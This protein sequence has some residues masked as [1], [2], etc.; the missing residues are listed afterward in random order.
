[1][2]KTRIDLTGE[3]QFKE[4]PQRA[5]RMRDLEASDW[6]AAEVPSSIFTNLVKVG[7]I[8]EAELKSN[9]E[10][11]EWVSEKQWIFKKTFDLPQRIIN[12]EK[13]EIV[14]EGLDTIAHIWLNGKLIGKTNNM[15]I[16]HRFGLTGMFRAKSNH[17]LV[18]FDSP[19]QYGR[20]LMSRYGKL[21][22]DE[23]SYPSRVYLRKAQYQFGWD[24]APSLPGCGIWR[25]V[26][27][28]A[29]DQARIEDICIRTIDCNEQFADIQIAVKLDRIS[30]DDFF[31]K[32]SLADGEKRV[33]AEQS[34]HF[35]KNED[36]NST[37][38][39]ITNPK[40]W[41]PRGYGG[42]PLYGLTAQLFCVDKLI[43]QAEQKFGIRTTKLNQSKDK[44]GQSFQF[45]VNGQA[46]Y[47]KGANWVPISLFAG[48][49]TEAD[50]EKLINFAVD[51]N[52]NMLR[53]WGGGYYEDPKF[54]ELCDELGMM[55]WQDF[56]FACAYYP[57]RNWFL[58]EVRTEAEAIIKRLRN[59]CSI[60][61][62]CGN[63]END[64]LHSIGK[65]GTGKKFY[66]KAIY[67]KLLPEL[68]GELDPGADYIPTTPL[69]MDK[70][71]NNS[72]AGS[73]H[74]WQV[75]SGLS[76]SRNYQCPADEVPRFVTEFGFQ[77]LPSFETLKTF[78]QPEQMHLSNAALEKH[79]YQSD[80][81]A[82]LHY[83]ISEQFAA[84]KTLDYFV[85]MSQLTQA[86]AMKLYVEHLRAHSF[87]NSGVLYWQHNDAYPA[88]TWSAIDYLYQPKAL[89]YYARRFFNPV[90]LTVVP[91]FCL[92]HPVLHPKLE[93]AFVHVIND[94]ILPLTARVICRLMDL[95]LNVIDEIT[96]PLSVNP[97][98]C[99]N[100]FR[101][102]NGFITP[103]DPQQSFMYFCLVH[104][105][106]TIAENSFF[107]LPDKYIT[108]PKPQITTKI[109]A[110]DGH[111]WELKLTSD[112]V[113]KDVRISTDSPSQLNDNFISLLS[114]DER[115]LR[116][117]TPQKQTS[118]PQVELLSVNSLPK[119]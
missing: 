42:Q 86:R 3:W 99:S 6:L 16:T 10:K 65:L 24:W 96:Q 105:D 12:S 79:N 25:P 47:A 100:P 94:T 74:Q 111:K 113:A 29:A 102:P 17:L 22:E 46:V 90:L 107:Y 97:F 49:A 4:Y 59:Y 67:Y 34:L 71:F 110:I 63:N 28:E 20:A 1:M 58:K 38:V 31:C 61:L 87:R 73:V 103:E 81:N 106:Y 9:P 75:W 40:L 104:D 7:R 45:E 109:S 82:R 33:Q 68:V 60:V 84:A 114:R 119:D 55:V 35:K 32:L 56:A 89:H 64:W 13:I 8:D 14:F 85:Y 50:Y 80:G 98:S 52:M 76:P 43:D 54:Y 112:V 70:N 78:T 51:A 37:I 118:P 95:S 11:F 21:S 117:Y 57:D 77:S 44:F 115:T 36:F 26:H 15:F 5:R 53:L 62:W 83:Y 116:I 108:W 30:G 101:L 88:I 18:K 19:L 41:W 2:A 39:R 48:L 91:S 27:L 23:N 69:G 92:K 66:G 93:S 72:D